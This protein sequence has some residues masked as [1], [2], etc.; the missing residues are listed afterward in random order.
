MHRKLMNDGNY[1][2]RIILIF[3]TLLNCSFYTLKFKIIPTE[4][5]LKQEIEIFISSFFHKTF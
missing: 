1:I 5:E 4:M 3:H 2:S